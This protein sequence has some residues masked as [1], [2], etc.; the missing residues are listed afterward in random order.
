MKRSFKNFQTLGSF[1]NAKTRSFF[2]N[3][4]KQKNCPQGMVWRR[5]MQ[6]LNPFGQQEIY[7]TKLQKFSNLRELSKCQ[8]SVIFSKFKKR[9]KLSPG[10]GLKKAYAKFQDDRAFRSTRKRLWKM[11]YQKWNR[12]RLWLWLRLRKD[13]NFGHFTMSITFEPRRISGRGK[14]L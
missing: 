3:S 14:R 4:K 11:R 13:E 5:R 10:N 8:N 2:R 12:L 9:K 1:Q 7:E 6:N